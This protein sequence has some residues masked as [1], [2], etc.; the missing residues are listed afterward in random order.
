MKLQGLEGFVGCVIVDRSGNSPWVCSVGD[1]KE[2][3]LN[4]KANRERMTQIMFETF[5]VPALY[6]AIQAALALYASGR[7]I[8]IVRFG[9]SPLAT[10]CKPYLV[11]ELC[12]SCTVFS[13]WIVGVNGL[14]R[15]YSQ[16]LD[17]AGFNAKEWKDDGFSLRDLLYAGFKVKE[18]K[19]AG[20][21]AKELKDAGFSL[22]ELEGAGFRPEELKDGGFSLRELKD[23]GFTA[24]ELKDAGFNAKELKDFGSSLR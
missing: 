16:D 11:M 24:E 20:C 12:Y 19:D 6:V 15:R 8:G 2:A 18:L 1:L 22:R 13:R 9:A 4:P 23:A 14:G 21:N 3:P 5:N 17:A 7:T 10:A